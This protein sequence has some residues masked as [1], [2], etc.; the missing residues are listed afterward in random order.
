MNFLEAF[1]VDNYRLLKDMPYI[2]LKDFTFLFGQNGSGKTSFIS[3]LSFIEQI[4]KN[5]K[6]YRENWIFHININKSFG[7]F[8]DIININNQNE[9]IKFYFMFSTNDDSRLLKHNLYKTPKRIEVIVE[10]VR[11]S[12]SPHKINLNSWEIKDITS[13]FYHRASLN[14]SS[15]NLI[16]FGNFSTNKFDENT[17]PYSKTLVDKLLLANKDKLAY[18]NSKMNSLLKHY[19]FVRG[20]F[21]YGGIDNE[22]DDLVDWYVDLTSQQEQV[23]EKIFQNTLSHFPEVEELLNEDKLQNL[24]EHILSPYYDFIQILFKESFLNNDYIPHLRLE[25]PRAFI[26]GDSKNSV[27]L[28]SLYNG[29]IG[30]SDSISIPKIEKRDMFSFPPEHPLS[31]SL[32]KALNDLN[33]GNSI[34]IDTSNGVCQIFV[35]RGGKEINISDDS[36]GFKQIFPILIKTLIASSATDI[37][38]EYNRNLLFIEQPELH[39]HPKLQSRLMAFLVKYSTASRLIIETHSEHFIKKIQIMFAEGILTDDNVLICYFDC[40]NGKTKIRKMEID[41]NGFFK[42]PWPDGFFEESYEL[43]KQL[44]Q[45]QRN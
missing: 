1:K 22:P 26:L 43:T 7:S 37:N 21:D 17:P 6:Q 23:N 24:I 14:D 42:E 36:S 30:L 44:L 19:K 34:R 28:N 13:G 39:L 4:I 9:P 33:L 12:S 8:D 29:I 5:L 16:L 41:E 11:N 38:Y 32:D 25:I 18:I 31:E 27:E 10:F 2:E 20:I 3:A 40:K 45:A 35:N 15:K